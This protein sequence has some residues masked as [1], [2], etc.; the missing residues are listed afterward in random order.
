MTPEQ[1]KCAAQHFGPWWVQESW[2]N[3][4]VAAYRA[5][6]LDYVLGDQRD[7]LIGILRE[8]PVGMLSD[9][10]AAARAGKDAEP[11][12]PYTLYGSV[13]KIPIIGQMTKGVSSFGGTSTIRTR[14]A[15]RKAMQDETV[16]AILLSIDSPGGT[17]AGT[18]DLAGEVAMAAGAGRKPVWAHI[19]DLGA[20]AAYYVA[21]GASRVT[22]NANALIGS[23]GTVMVVQD[24]SKMADEMGVKVHVLATG[25][26]KATG[27]PG[28]EVTA[29]QLEAEQEFVDDLGQQFV[30][31]VNASR[32]TKLKMGK[33]AADG[34]VFI[35]AKA[36][37]FGLIDAVQSFGQTLGELQAALAAEDAD[38]LAR[39][40]VAQEGLL[41]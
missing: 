29:K 15:L 22:A 37:G 41:T 14:Q 13:A 7:T 40:R 25:P 36:M 26:N 31:H 21:A 18:P 3:Q 20:S 16:R 12:P 9:I 39:A 4:A 34:R 2:L 10:P 8:T 32:G 35:A 19:D 6:L 27:T 24:T 17:V 38:A 23:I 28:V 1:M 30:D 33:G 5:G 11:P